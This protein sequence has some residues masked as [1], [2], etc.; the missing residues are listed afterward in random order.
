MKRIILRGIHFIQRIIN[1]AKIFPSHMK[2]FG[3]KIA[4]VIFM[5]GLIPPGKSEKYIHTIDEYISEYLQS[6][7]EKYKNKNYIV[8]KENEYNEKTP[9]WCCWWQGEE[10]MPEL[11]KMCNMRLKQV[12]PSEKAELKMITLDN[13]TNY[14]TFPK[15][16]IEKFNEGK[17]SMTALSDVLRVALLSEYGGFW[18]DSTVFISE[19]FPMEFISNDF[20]CQRMYD[21]QKWSR[22]AC[23]GRWCGFLISGSKGN[24]IF[25]FLREAFYQWWKDYDC[26][27][28]YVILDYFLLTA[29]RNLEEVKEIIDNVPDNNIDVFEMYKVLHLPYSEEL[30]NKLTETTNLHKL[31]Y[32]ID[33]KKVAKDGKETLYSH[34]LKCVEQ[35]KSI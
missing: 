23:K 27:I 34:L 33:L 14:V 2:N 15:Y 7:V 6:L 11:V 17:I 31:T 8:T 25:H 35:N 19:E 3:F 22:E 10:K 29:Y 32:K 30:V 5:D 24:I 21:P 20:Y 12:L 9:V 13:Y 4:W 26:V 18:I 1:E 28:D 16:I